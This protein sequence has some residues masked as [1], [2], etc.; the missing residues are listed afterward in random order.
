MYAAG[1]KS[2]IDPNLFHLVF[3]TVLRTST[4]PKRDFHLVFDI[5]RHSANLTERIGALRSLAAISDLEL[6]NKLMYEIIMDTSKVKTQDTEDA[7][8]GLFYSSFPIKQVFELKWKWWI[9]QF[10]ELA[11]MMDAK[12]LPI[13]TLLESYVG[14]DYALMVEAWMHEDAHRF[15]KLESVHREL[16]NGIENIRIRSAWFERDRETTLKWLVEKA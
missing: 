6:L 14:E 2:A 11:E 10:D 16:E 5:Y 3:T 9:Q 15:K 1:Q 4:E 7:L 13:D 8:F 12:N